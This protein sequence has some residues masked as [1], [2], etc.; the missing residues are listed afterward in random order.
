M[1]EEELRS[2]AARFSQGLKNNEFKRDVEPQITP[3]HKYESWEARY[4]AESEALNKY[5]GSPLFEM[6]NNEL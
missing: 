3:T 6:I 1:D 4:Q 5:I 2:R